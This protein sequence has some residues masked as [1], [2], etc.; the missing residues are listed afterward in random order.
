MCTTD[1]IT[2]SRG[3]GCDV[4]P[5]SGHLRLPLLRTQPKVGRLPKLMATF[6]L[7]LWERRS[8]VNANIV[9]A[10]TRAGM[11]FILKVAPTVSPNPGSASH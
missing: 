4:S 6:E 9:H 7:N 1:W 2:E 11:R 10:V 5:I 8:S 3:R